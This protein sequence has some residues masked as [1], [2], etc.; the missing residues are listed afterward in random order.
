MSLA[1]PPP[2]MTPCRCASTAATPSALLVGLSMSPPW[3]APLPARPCGAPAGLKWLPALVASAA[4]QSPFSCTWKPKR[5]LGASP[6]TS[7]RT[8]TPPVT[9]T[10]PSLPLTRLPEAEART[11]VASW[12]VLTGAGS[13]GGGGATGSVVLQAA[14]SSRPVVARQARAICIIGSSGPS[15]PPRIPG[16]AHGADEPAAGASAPAASGPELARHRVAAHAQQRRRL[17]PPPAGV[18]QRG[19]EQGTVEAFARLRMQFARAGAQAVQRPLP[20]LHV[21]LP[22]RSRRGRAGRH[23]RLQHLQVLQGDGLAGGQR[24]QA[25]AQV[26][27]LAHVARPVHRLQRGQRAGLEALGAAAQLARGTVQ[28]GGGQQR[29]VAA[30]LAQRRDLQ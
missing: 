9:G 13:A 19:V 4:L 22:R 15:G 10:R 28:E 23:R 2:R 7:P 30:A 16:R 8:C 11:T 12:A 3:W 6:P 26:L 18:F 17:H 29:D 5:P 1:A 24:G 14:S 20:Q 27:Q 21:P 25:P